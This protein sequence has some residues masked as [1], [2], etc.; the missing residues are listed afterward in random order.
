MVLLEAA[1]LYVGANLLILLVLAVLVVRARRTH[2]VA[3]GDGGNP[4][5]LRAMRAHANAAEYIP[6]GL[7]GL[8]TLAL[9]DPAAKLWMI[10][11][12]GAT[13]TV[14]RLA[15]GAGLTTGVL[16]MGRVA[17]MTL[18]WLAYLGLVAAL[19]YVGLSPR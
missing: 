3:L 14:G 4:R 8:V 16:N 1:A 5:V 17:G 18:T 9:F 11:A 19:F 13:L 15:H 2:R 10:H 7:I 6:A 12:C